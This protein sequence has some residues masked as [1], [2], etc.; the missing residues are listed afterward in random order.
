MARPGAHGWFRSIQNLWLCL[1]KLNTS[2]HVCFRDN[3]CIIIDCIHTGPCF[4][5][6]TVC[7]MEC[8]KK[9][10]WSWHVIETW[11]TL[12]LGNYWGQ[13]RSTGETEFPLCFLLCTKDAH[14]VQ[15]NQLRS[16]EKP[17]REK[18]CS[19]LF[20]ALFS[21]LLY[22]LNFLPESTEIC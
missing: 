2:T 6:H 10:E 7:K 9:D 13:L 19:V 5:W 4:L 12:V 1:A 22:F 20:S 17:K 16:S 21:F 14:N 8:W 15:Q 11:S 18:K 3:A